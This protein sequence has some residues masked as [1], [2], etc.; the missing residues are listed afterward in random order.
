MSDPTPTSG[1]AEATKTVD[2]AGK[3]VE[4][5]SSDPVVKAAVLHAADPDVL[6]GLRAAASATETETSLRSEGQRVVSMLWETTQKTIAM[7]TVGGAVSLSVV[8]VVF[9][10]WLALEADVRIA[11][12][13]FVA[14]AA[15]LV[16]GFYYGRTNHQR[17]GGPGGDTAGTR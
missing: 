2:A 12:F 11:A 17:V 16:I 7:V 4:A 6:A 13:M 14:S 1:P 9:G 3:I 15:N 5:V 10:K 8:V